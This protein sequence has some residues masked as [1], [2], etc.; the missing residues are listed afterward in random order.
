MPA[1]PV[2]AEVG[3]RGE[4]PRGEVGVGPQA[5]ALL[6]KFDEGLGD[7][8]LGVGRVA[9]VAPGV[10]EERALPPRDQAVEGAVVAFLEF[11]EEREV[12]GWG[13]G[14]GGETCRRGGVNRAGV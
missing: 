3:E 14:H 8:V 7:E 6:V 13:S 5:F 2:V 4:E 9:H 12:V 11:L 1:V 10:R